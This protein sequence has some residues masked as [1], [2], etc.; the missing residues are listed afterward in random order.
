MHLEFS[1]AFDTDSKKIKYNQWVQVRSPS[2]LE[3]Q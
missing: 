2:G 3:N 1:K